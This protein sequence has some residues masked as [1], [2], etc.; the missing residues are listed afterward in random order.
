[1]LDELLRSRLAWTPVKAVNR[2]AAERKVLPADIVQRIDRRI[3]RKVMKEWSSRVGY[4][5]E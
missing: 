4:E 3:V 5:E 1:M 2:A